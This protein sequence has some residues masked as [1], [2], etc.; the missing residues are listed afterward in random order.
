MIKNNLERSLV[1]QW[2]GILAFTAKAQG[3]IYGQGTWILQAMQCG[4]KE[5]KKLISHV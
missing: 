4:Q 3:L 2:L 5:R 1:A